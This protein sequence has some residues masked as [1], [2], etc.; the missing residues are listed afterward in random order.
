MWSLFE[1]SNFHFLFLE[2]ILD[3]GAIDDVEE[4][5]ELICCPGDT[6]LHWAE[7][8][9]AH[10]SANIFSGALAEPEVGRAKRF[11]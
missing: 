6:V 10:H 7:F 4:I 5:F 3:L 11:A 2:E 9:D 1:V 8:L